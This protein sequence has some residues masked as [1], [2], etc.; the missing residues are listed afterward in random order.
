VRDICDDA[1]GA[2][3]A[4]YHNEWVMS[5][6]N[7]SCHIWMSHVT[8]ERVMSRIHRNFPRLWWRTRGL[9]RVTPQWVGHVPY[10]W[11]M[12]H[13]NESCHVYTETSED[14]DD[15]LGAGGAW[16]LWYYG[17][18]SVSKIDNFIG[19]FCKRALEKRSYSA[20]ETYN[21]IDPTTCSHPIHES[22]MSRMS[23]RI[24]KI[25]GLSCRI[26]SLF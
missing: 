16:H 3:G 18:A 23:S 9:R 25:I 15:A 13:M 10:E 5:H 17:V 1:L 22:D 2:W 7:E 8:Y 6:V 14:F 21:F 12:S 11:V 4:G 26:A 24:D 19:R 20:K